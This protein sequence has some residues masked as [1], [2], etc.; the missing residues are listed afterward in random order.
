MK[1]FQINGVDITYC[2]SKDER[3]TLDGVLELHI[4]YYYSHILEYWLQT[5]QSTDR[6]SEY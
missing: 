4:D 6:R 2:R 5:L 3:E 1:R